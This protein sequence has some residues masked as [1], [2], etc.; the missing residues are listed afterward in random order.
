MELTMRIKFDLKWKHA[1]IEW[2]D[3]FPSELDR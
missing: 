3:F 2:G 1:A